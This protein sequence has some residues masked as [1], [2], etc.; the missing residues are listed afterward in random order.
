MCRA[1]SPLLDLHPNLGL[2]PRLVCRRAFGPHPMGLIERIGTRQGE[3]KGEYR[4]SSLR[5]E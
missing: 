1:F 4:G 3:G 5:S 2:R